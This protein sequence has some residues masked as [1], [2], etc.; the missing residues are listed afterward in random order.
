MAKQS[1][2]TDQ[3]TSQ[4]LR[5][6]VR[7]TRLYDAW[8]NVH[9]LTGIWFGWILPPLPAIFLMALWEPF[10]TLLLSPWL[11]KRGLVF[12]YEAW[13]NSLTDIIFDAIG[14]GF[15]WVLVIHV[16]HPQ[17]IFLLFR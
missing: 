1:P 11:L 8:S 5:N 7:N 10:E 2:E 16:G 12:G 9:I 13:Q 3:Q 17:D 4:R 14:V 15:G 6:L